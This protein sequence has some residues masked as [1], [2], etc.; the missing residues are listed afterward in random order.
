MGND[1]II[2]LDG[3]EWIG[4]IIPKVVEISKDLWNYS[5]FKTS[6]S[7]DISKETRRDYEDYLQYVLFDIREDTDKALTKL[8]KSRLKSKKTD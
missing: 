4:Q 2:L 5:T 1:Y 3:N 6:S 7:Q 8:K